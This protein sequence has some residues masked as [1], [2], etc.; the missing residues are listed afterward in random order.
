MSITKLRYLFLRAFSKLRP[1]PIFDSTIDSSAKIGPGSRILSSKFGRY[2]Y[3]GSDC[4]IVNCDIG[5]FCSIADNVAIGPGVHPIDHVSTSPIFLRGRNVLGRNISNHDLP[6]SQRVRI[7]NDVWIG[8]DAKISSGV[9]IG[10]GAIVGMG[11]VVTKD[12]EPY[13]VV[14]GVPAHLLRYRFDKEVVRSLLEIRWWDLKD[15]QLALHAKF[16]SDPCRYLSEYHQ[17]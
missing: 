16:F 6:S 10:D 13:A 11:S 3:C 17:Q 12:V 4:L 8:L 2:S 9:N 15:D 14:G 1:S 7:G 5:A